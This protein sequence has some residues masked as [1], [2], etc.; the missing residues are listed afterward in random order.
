MTDPTFE[1][2]TSHQDTVGPP[3]S[4]PDTAVQALSPETVAVFQARATEAA[5]Q[6]DLRERF[7]DLL[8]IVGNVAAQKLLGL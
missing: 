5:I 1:P 7:M 6:S 3:N 4:T 8:Q 2:S